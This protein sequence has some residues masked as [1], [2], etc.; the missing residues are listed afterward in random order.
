MQTQRGGDKRFEKIEK[1]NFSFDEGGAM[2]T[3]KLF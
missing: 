1:G 3:L 2:V